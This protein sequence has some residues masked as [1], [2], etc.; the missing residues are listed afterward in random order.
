MLRLIRDQNLVGRGEV[1]L[2]PECD[3]G[4]KRKM[5]CGIDFAQEILDIHNFFGCRAVINGVFVEKRLKF[6]C[7]ERGGAREKFINTYGSEFE[8]I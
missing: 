1:P 2:L 4:S 3:S 7:S 6:K 8:F 5:S